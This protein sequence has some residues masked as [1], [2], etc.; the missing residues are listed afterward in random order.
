VVSQNDDFARTNDESVSKEEQRFTRRRVIS[1]TAAAA[2]AG[3]FGAAALEQA[4]A[5]PL[6]SARYAHVLRQGT[7]PAD[8]APPEK[9]MLIFPDNVNTAKVIDFYEQVYQRPSAAFS[10]IL[11]EPLIRMNRN[12]E[13][14]P[15]QAESWTS[16]EDGMTWTFKLKNELTWSDGNPLTAADW[17]KTFQYG[18]D[19]EHVWDFTWFFMGVIKGWD[20]AVAGKVGLD[21]IGVRQGTNEYELVIET[22]VPAPYI[23]A[24]ML[25]SLPLSKA[26]LESTGP[27]YNTDPATSVT[28]G[29]YMLTEWTPQQQL[30]YTKNPKYTGSMKVMAEKLVVKLATPD[31]YFTMYQNDEIDY[32]EEPDPAA[33]TLMMDDEATAQEVHQGV[34]DF[35]TWYIFFDV[36]KPPFD[37]KMVRQA[38]SHAIDRDTLKEQVLGPNGIQAYSWLAP[39]F[40]ASQREA[41][42]DIQKFDPA[43]AKDL[44]SQAGFPDGKDF[45]KQTMWLR[46][47]NPL[48]K[49]VAGAL[50][51]MIKESLNI[52]VELEEHD[53]QGFTAALNA[54]PTEILLGYVRYGM[55]YLDP[56]NMLSVWK[57]G[58]RHSWSNPD[59]DAK[60]K[61]ASEYL[62]DPAE[63]TA[64][65]Q[66]A[67]RILVEDVPGVFVYHGTRV[68]FIKPWLKGDFIAPDKNGISA[69]HW[70]AFT[71]MSTVPE[72]IY[73]SGDAPDRG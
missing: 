35:P 24:M 61:E 10:D 8:A 21:T 51:A 28:C 7:P 45:P 41:L 46:A 19:P 52:D 15:G 6:N 53:S 32:L 16:T 22:Q 49:T 62:G 43:M 55:D 30:V 68:Q 33:L 14:I 11:S 20:D 42:Q 64:L 71:T 67:E 54:K 48:D 36:T 31:T 39:G 58:G 38:W 1:T 5:A 17:V 37:N 44:L 47:P 29:P 73:V 69:L 70:P 57:S 63:R 59:F 13:N 26:A 65:F 40:P 25:Y 27:L 18:A 9:Q 66:E 12:F 2:A 4:G 56:S 34:G 50:A 23:P 60:L 72:E 3:I